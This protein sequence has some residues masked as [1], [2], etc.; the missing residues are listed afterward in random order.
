MNLG[1]GGGCKQMESK[2]ILSKRH[3]RSEFIQILNVLTNTDQHIILYLGHTIKTFL[4]P[5]SDMTRTLMIW[6]VQS[7]VRLN[8]RVRPLVLNE[9]G[10]RGAFFPNPWSHRC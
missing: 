8:A 1:G 7:G 6:F 2:K 3:T 5:A 10:R 4:P 9:Q